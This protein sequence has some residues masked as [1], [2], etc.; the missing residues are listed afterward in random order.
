LINKQTNKTTT[1]KQNGNRFL[2]AEPE[3]HPLSQLIWVLMVSEKVSLCFS[4]FSRWIVL[5]HRKLSPM[6][7]LLLCILCASLP[8]AAGS[9]PVLSGHQ[10]LQGAQ[11][12]PP[13]SVCGLQACCSSSGRDSSPQRWKAVWQCWQSCWS[14]YH[15]EREGKVLLAPKSARKGR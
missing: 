14:P 6:P 1:Q 11:R 7:G 2:P 10:M 15:H 9:R 8:S 5:L 4:N 13:A 12:L 3:G